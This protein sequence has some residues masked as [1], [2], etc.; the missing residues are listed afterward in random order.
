MAAAAKIKL[1]KAI[2]YFF[3]Q[4][5]IVTVQTKV[6]FRSSVAI[7]LRLACTLPVFS[8]NTKLNLEAVLFTSLE[9]LH[10][11]ETAPFEALAVNEINIEA[12]SEFMVDI[13]NAVSV[14][15]KVSIIGICGTFAYLQI[16]IMNTTTDL[17]SD[18]FTKPSKGMLEA[19]WAAEVGDDV[20]GEDPTVNKLEQKTADTFG[21]EAGLYCSSGTMTNQTAIKVL[22]QP[23]QEVICDVQAHIYKYET[24]GM[25]FNSGVT[26]RLIDGDRGRLSPQD[27]LHHI[28]A[29]NVHFA[30]TSLVALENTSNRGGGSYYTLYQ[31]KEIHEL[32]KNNDLKLHLDGARIFNALAE[33]GDSPKDVGK[34]FDTISVC[35][36]KGLGAP[37]GS[38]LLSSKENINKARRIRK[39]FGGGMRQAGF[40]AAAAL[41]AIDNNIKRL[42]EDHK[43]AKQIEATLKELSYVENVLPVDTNIIIFELNKSLSNEDFLGKLALHHIKALSTSN[44]TIRFVTHLD[45]TDE[46]LGDL[47]KVLKGM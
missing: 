36:S 44:Q 30:P 41:Y 3:G 11:M 27:I 14:S 10:V 37:V 18:T 33:T 12:A 2:I 39:V 23:L 43:R 19:M 42:K 28:N 6:N 29:E 4:V 9:V 47:L 20:F 34:L 21:M 26:A 1:L 40:M 22:T 35:F 5:S 31:M 32:V 46:M 45:F 15:K 8:I 24:G 17:R 16:Q 25:A 38:V 7:A 13:N